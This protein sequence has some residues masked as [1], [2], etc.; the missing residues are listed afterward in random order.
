MTNIFSYF[1]DWIY[2]NSTL[3]DEMVNDINKLSQEIEKLSNI[4]KEKNKKIEESQINIKNLETNIKE[5][6]KNYQ[7]LIEEKNTLFG[8]NFSYKSQI[9]TLR[10]E[11]NKLSVD[12]KILLKSLSQ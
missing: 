12:N 1:F 7:Y 2:E 10:D 11:K 5:H 3:H 4:V 8:E 6:V 9:K